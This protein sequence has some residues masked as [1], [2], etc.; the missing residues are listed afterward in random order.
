MMKPPTR[1]ESRSSSQS[2]ADDTSLAPA[3]RHTRPFGLNQVLNSHSGQAIVL[4]A[5][6]VIAQVLLAVTFILAARSTAPA[7]FGVI[8]AGIAA[9]T[10]MCGVIDF[11]GHA[12][13]LRRYAKHPLET[14]AGPAVLS[15]KILLASLLAL[16]IAVLGVTTSFAISK[17]WWFGLYGVCLLSEQASQVSLRAEMA[18]GKVALAS[19]LSRTTALAGYGVSVLAGAP[20]DGLWVALCIGSLVGGCFAN[21][22]SL[23]SHRLRFRMRRLNP[24]AEGPSFGIASIATAARNLDL[25]ILTAVAGP[26]SAGV[27]A[28]VNRW[29]QPMS[30]LPNSVSSML[31]PHVA[32][33]SSWREVVAHARRVSWMLFS[34]ALLCVAVGISADWLVLI[35]IGAQYEDAGAV[36]RILA[37]GSLVAVVNQPLYSVLLTVGAHRVVSAITV[38]GTVAQLALVVGL[39]LQ[40]G[41]IGA[42]WSFALTQVLLLLAYLSAALRFRWEK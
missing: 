13:W 36:L 23:A 33:A 19:L 37:L 35:L 9:G 25:P 10:F 29:T 18:V 11:G 21:Y 30:I 3:R 24:W 8:A 40:F 16:A 42:A 28:A 39:G 22:S 31:I 17:Y 20:L 6:T 12:Y 32:R 2:R 1:S 27:Y 5:S 14:H 4:A 7:D 15:Q 38:A 34:T 41:A 26:T